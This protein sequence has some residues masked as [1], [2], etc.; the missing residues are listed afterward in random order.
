MAAMIFGTNQAV[1]ISHQ[2]IKRVLHQFSIAIPSGG[3]D[4]KKKKVI[5]HNATRQSFDDPDDI[6]RD[7]FLWTLES[8]ST[9]SFHRLNSA[10]HEE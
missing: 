1:N 7:L 6:T 10:L 2:D 5:S 8:S 3:T 4:Y 9:H